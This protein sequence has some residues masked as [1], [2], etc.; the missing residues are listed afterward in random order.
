MTVAD[1]LSALDAWAPPGQKADFDRVGLQVGD[2]A[3]EVSRVLVALDL[4]PAVVDEAA[5]V[6][7]QMIV[8]HHPLLFKP[9]GRATA[10]D[11]VGS[12][13]WRLG[14]AGVSY[15]AVHT[16]LDAATGGVSYALAEQIGL[17]GAEI[18]APLDGVMRKV[19]V[20]VPEDSAGA[21]RAAMAEAGAGRIGAYEGCSFTLEGTG[22]FVPRHGATPTVGDVGEPEA[23]AEA[24]IEAVVPKWAVRGLRGAI[25]DAHPYETPAIDVIALDGAATRQGYGVIG[26]LPEPEPLPAF[27]D[28]VRDALGAGALR[29]VGNDHQVI[30]RVAVCGGSG[31]SFLSAAIRAGAD[32]YVTADVTYHR[33]FEA[34]DTEG[35]P[36]LALIDPGHYETEAVTERLI[37]A[38][39]GEALGVETVVTRQR[40]SPM[41]TFAG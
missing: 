30:R 40:T 37:A 11:P 12:L 17:E 32:A 36:R 8:T 28:R 29:F 21:V 18:L 33:W 9:V 4:T 22:R 27:L 20:F 1:V 35:A 13:V 6:G 15:A 19:V 25:T 7:A 24:R 2:P 41:R 26:H 5:E 10:D 31:L 23:V 34:L 3:A 14:R 16:N 39:L 38:H